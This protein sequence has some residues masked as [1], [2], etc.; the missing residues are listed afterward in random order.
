MSEIDFAE[1]EKAM[2]ELVSKA[3]GEDR[4]QKLHVAAQKRSE[5][6]KRAEVAQ[7]QGDIATKRIIVAS[8][9]IRSNP[10]RR[11]PAPPKLNNP[12]AHLQTSGRVMDFKPPSP[13]PFLSSNSTNISPLNNDITPIIHPEP[14]L[15]NLSN[16]LD[17]TIGDL[18]DD[19]L[20]KQVSINEDESPREDTDTDGGIYSKKE[21]VQNQNQNISTSL[22]DITGPSPVMSINQEPT[23]A[24]Q[25]NG[26]ISD[27][28]LNTQNRPEDKLLEADEL[29]EEVG[30]VHKIYGQKLPKSYIYST[31]KT[32]SEAKL[33]QKNQK[34]NKIKTKISRGFSFYFVILMVVAAISV[35]GIAIYLYFVY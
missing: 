11:F 7:E 21:S 8:N 19:Y 20:I 33:K 12:H 10:A 6:A 25:N 30:K 9:N 17:K 15:E 1:I 35:W 14:R 29:T 34:Q 4:T 2:A 24:E 16:N 28:A 27:E 22:E 18:S 26:Y 32:N 31:K 23:M 13:T 3:Q 5:T